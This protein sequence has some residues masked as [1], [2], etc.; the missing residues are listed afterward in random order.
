MRAFSHLPKFVLV[1]EAL[2]GI[3]LVLSYFTLHQMLP[4]PAPFSGPAAA[5]VMIFAGIALMLPAA[6][7]MMWRTAK[8]LAPDLFDAKRDKNTPGEKHDADH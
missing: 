8:A 3:L 4:L 2:G 5:T 1:L 7:V 6:I